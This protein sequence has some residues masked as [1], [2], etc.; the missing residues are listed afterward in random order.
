[1]WSIFAILTLNFV[2]SLLISAFLV[3]CCVCLYV[4]KNRDYYEKINKFNSLPTVPLLGNM[5]P[6]LLSRKG[7]YT[8]IH[9]SYYV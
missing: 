4:W 3:I 5:L 9:L 2:P 7:K 1:M 8:L 6:V